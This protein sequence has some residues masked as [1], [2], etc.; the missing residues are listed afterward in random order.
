[1]PPSPS[2]PASPPTTRAGPRPLPSS[3]LGYPLYHRCCYYFF[4]CLYHHPPLLL[5]HRDPFLYPSLVLPRPDPRAGR[6]CPCRPPDA[7]PPPSPHVP[8]GLRSWNAL[9]LGPTPRRGRPRPTLARRSSCRLLLLLPTL[10]SMTRVVRCLAV[11]ASLDV[12]SRRS[13]C[14]SFWRGR[15]RGKR[16]EGTVIATYIQ[17][18]GS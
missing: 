10:A 17:D 1:M 7:P 9:R 3:P 14:S 6:C 16:R 2:T 15:G 8:P 18:F 12:R 5:V 4:R 13:C 11:S